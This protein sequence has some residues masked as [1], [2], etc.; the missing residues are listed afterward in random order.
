MINYGNRK[1]IQA[2]SHLNSWIKIKLYFLCKSISKFF[3][4]PSPSGTCA[5]SL[6]FMLGREPKNI[7]YYPCNEENY[8]DQVLDFLSFDKNKYTREIF[9]SAILV[10]IFTLWGSFNL[11]FVPQDLI[12]RINSYS[13]RMAFQRNL[14]PGF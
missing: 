3:P 1:T 10:I 9:R 5:L 11:F 2:W 14:L 4:L 8:T 13:E 6:D 12:G 7:F